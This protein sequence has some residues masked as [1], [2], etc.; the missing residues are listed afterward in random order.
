MAE[1]FVNEG[2]DDMIAGLVKAGTQRTTL[3]CG[4]FTSQTAT[5]VPAATAVLSTATGVTEASFTNYARQSI[6]SGAWGANAAGSPDGRQTTAGVVTFP[7]I[8]ATVGGAIN[9]CFLATAST[10]GIGWGYANFNEGA[11]T[12]QVGLVITV[13]LT[14]S[15]GA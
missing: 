15:L 7:A 14:F 13:T 4:L 10:A 1:I 2:L 11:I 5:T 6:A 12:P 9:G 3:Y 8:G